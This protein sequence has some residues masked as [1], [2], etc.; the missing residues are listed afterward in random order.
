MSLDLDR[1]SPPLLPCLPLMSLALDRLS[2][3]LLP[4]LLLMILD[5]ASP[6]CRSFL[7]RNEALY[8]RMIFWKRDLCLIE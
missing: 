8:F 5:S 1:L 7:R 2:P 6:E 3:P 4:P